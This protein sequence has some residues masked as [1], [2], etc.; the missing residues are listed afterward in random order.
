[1]PWNMNLGVAFAVRQKYLRLTFKNLFLNF[2]SYLLT[3]VHN[4]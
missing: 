2:L 4:C 3:Y 1:M